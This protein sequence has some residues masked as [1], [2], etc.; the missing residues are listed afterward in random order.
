MEYREG[1]LVVIKSGGLP[2]TVRWF[3]DSAA[4]KATGREM[5]VHCDWLDNNG[6]HHYALFL[7][8]QLERWPP[9]PR[10]AP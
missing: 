6:A 3:I 2:M 4:A 7:P 1:D 5:G 8:Q 9:K 10:E